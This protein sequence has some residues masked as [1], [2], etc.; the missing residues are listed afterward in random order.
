MRSD[1][2]GLYRHGFQTGF[3]RHVVEDRLEDRAF[4]RLPGIQGGDAVTISV[5]DRGE[6][7]FASL[8]GIERDLGVLGQVDSVDDCARGNGFEAGLCQ[9]GGRRLYCHG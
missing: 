6:A 9:P 1:A 8:T 7:G 5:P 3:H 4:E 2:R